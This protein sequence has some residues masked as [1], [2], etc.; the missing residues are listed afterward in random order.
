MY[1]FKRCPPETP[2]LVRVKTKQPIQKCPAA[3]AL[4]KASGEKAGK[5]DKDK[6][7]IQKELTHEQTRVVKRI[8]KQGEVLRIIA[9]AGMFMHSSLIHHAHNYQMSTKTST[10]STCVHIKLCRY[11]KDYNPS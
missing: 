5:T 3:K 6:K 2:K 9:L 1:L 11:W 10:F 7:R 8:L 4:R